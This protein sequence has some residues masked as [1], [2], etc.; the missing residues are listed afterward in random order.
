MLKTNPETYRELKAMKNATEIAKYYNVSTNFVDDAYDFL[1]ADPGNEIRID[2][3]IITFRDN[4]KK[5]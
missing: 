1:I 3:D 5:Y 2:D 4:Q